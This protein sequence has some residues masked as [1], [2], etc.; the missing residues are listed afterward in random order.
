[1][2]TI[3]ATTINKEHLDYNW[4]IIYPWGQANIGEVMTEDIQELFDHF[5]SLQNQQCES[6]G[7]FTII[8]TKQKEL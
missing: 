7:S 5:E 6:D 8:I 3:P 4:T 1:M 2:L